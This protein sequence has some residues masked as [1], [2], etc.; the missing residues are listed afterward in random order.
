MTSSFS[1]RLEKTWIPACIFRQAG[2]KFACPRQILE[3]FFL[4]LV[5]DLLGSLPIGQVIMKNY[6]QENPLVPDNWTVF[7]W[8]PVLVQIYTWVINGSMNSDMFCPRTQPNDHCSLNLLLW[9][10]QRYGYI[11]YLVSSLEWHIRL[12]L[13]SSFSSMTQQGVFLPP[14]EGTQVHHRVALGI[15]F[16]ETTDI[17]ICCRSIL[18]SG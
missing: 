6:L 3:Y 5:D 13:N 17:I 18:N 11:V 7:S 8:S 9:S 4:Q 12:V 16:V 2:L 14:P 10:R 1:Q 15:K